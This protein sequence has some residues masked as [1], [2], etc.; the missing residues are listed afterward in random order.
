[1]SGAVKTVFSAPTPSHRMW[2]DVDIHGFDT[3]NGLLLSHLSVTEG[4][5]QHRRVALLSYAANFRVSKGG[6]VQQ[7]Q[8]HSAAL[9]YA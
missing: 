5:P 8:G 9:H 2:R 1:M 7:E 6:T 3:F 4:E